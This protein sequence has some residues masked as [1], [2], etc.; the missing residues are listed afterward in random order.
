[1]KKTC[2]SFALVAVILSVAALLL[3]AVQASETQ[4]V[5]STEDTLGE[6][7]KRVVDATAGF[8]DIAATAVVEYKNDEVLAKIGKRYAQQLELK[9]AL[10][11]F[12]GPDKTRVEGALGVMKFVYI[13]NHDH[14]I[15]RIKPIGYDKKESIVDKPHR[16]QDAID[17][18]L[19]TKDL[20]DQYV[21]E[22]ETTEGEGD[23]LCHVLDLTRGDE[24]SNMY[25]IWINAKN[26]SLTR[27]EKYD[28]DK[29]THRL[30]YTYSEPQQVNGMWIPTKIEM[31]SKNGELAGTTRIKDITVNTGLDDA[32]FK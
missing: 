12:K 7:Q 10:I 20:W 29:V 30:T 15:V 17:M 27:L 25:R 16:R 21:I 22:K 1:M 3:P 2:L 8:K 9:K 32:L 6:L 5:V 19:V 26:L 31:L 23:A 4:P 28:P 14:K 11:R 13:T 24:F 18:G